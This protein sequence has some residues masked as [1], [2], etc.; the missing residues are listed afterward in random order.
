MESD[1]HGKLNYWDYIKDM[2]FL[3][4]SHVPQLQGHESKDV[5]KMI[6]PTIHDPEYK[7]LHP[8][9]STKE[10]NSVMFVWVSPVLSRFVYVTIIL[11]DD[12]NTELMFL[13]V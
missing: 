2:K 13:C 3:L 10:S 1:D 8:T 5:V 9:E 12:N 7:C 4:D 11:R 6:K